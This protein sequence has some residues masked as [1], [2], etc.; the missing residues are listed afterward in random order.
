MVLPGKMC[1]YI[2]SG[3][4]MPSKSIPPAMMVATKLEI[5]NLNCFFSS[6]SALPMLSAAYKE[7][8]HCAS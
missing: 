1:G 6:D 4:F 8:K 3:T 7:L 5:F 2:F